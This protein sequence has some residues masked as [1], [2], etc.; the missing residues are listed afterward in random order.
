MIIHGSSVGVGMQ[1]LVSR[2]IPNFQEYISGV[3]VGHMGLF[4]A[5]S[6]IVPSQSEMVLLCNDISHWL[7]AS[8]E[9][10]LL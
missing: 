9:S 2:F 4:R 6:R 10:A 5:D 3:S 1:T 8:L 7:G